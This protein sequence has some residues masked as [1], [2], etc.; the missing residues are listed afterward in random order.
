MKIVS[1]RWNNAAGL[2]VGTFELHGYTAIVRDKTP[3]RVWRSAHRVDRQLRRAERR[4][5]RA[6]RVP[7]PE[8][9]AK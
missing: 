4:R 2:F 9:K 8:L 3:R 7:A 6:V 5:L 1:M